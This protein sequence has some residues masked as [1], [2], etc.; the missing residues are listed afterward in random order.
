MF[1]RNHYINNSTARKWSPKSYL[2]MPNENKHSSPLYPWPLGSYPSDT[3]L[4]Y[5]PCGALWAFKGVLFSQCIATT[6]YIDLEQEW[7]LVN[8]VSVFIVHENLLLTETNKLLPV[9]VAVMLCYFILS[10]SRVHLTGLRTHQIILGPVLFGPNAVEVTSTGLI[11]GA[12]EISTLVEMVVDV[13]CID[14]EPGTF[15]WSFGVG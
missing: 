15:G 12:V 1:R 6:S 4:E 5:N 7:L 9:P 8:R 13:E 10:M 11:T 3:K 14:G 2:L